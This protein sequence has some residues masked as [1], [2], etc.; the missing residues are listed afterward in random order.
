MDENDQLTL[1]DEIGREC[2]THE[3][4]EVHTKF[5][6]GRPEW[7]RRDDLGVDEIFNIKMDLEWV[8]R[9]GVAWI[10]LSRTR[11]LLANQLKG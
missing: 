11:Q 3:E 1:Y 5:L 8:L 4:L 6:V 10:H 7:K 2:N 9:Y